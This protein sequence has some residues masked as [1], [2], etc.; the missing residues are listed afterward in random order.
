[1]V[2]PSSTVS[3]VEVHGYEPAGADMGEAHEVGFFH[4]AVRGRHGDEITLLELADRQIGRYIL[5]GGH[6]EDI[7]YG[8]ALGGPA[9]LGYVIDL[10]R[11]DLPLV[12]KEED[13]AVGRGYEEVGDKILLFG[14]HAH[15]PLAAPLLYLEQARRVPLYIA[16]AGDG[17]DHVLLGY[18]VLE[19]YLACLIDYLGAPFVA[20]PLPYFLELVYDDGHEKSF[21]R[22]Y[23]LEARYQLQYVLIL[24]DYLVPL[25]GGKPLE[26][27]VEDGL[28]LYLRELEVC[29]EAALGLLRALRGPDELYDRVQVV[30]GD[31]QPLK[32][33]RPL[34]G[35]LEVE[36]YPSGDD[37]PP[38][39]D[40]LFEERSQGQHPGL[41]LDDGEV[42]YAERGLHLGMEVEVV[43][44]DFSHL[45]PLDL[46][47]DPHA[48]AVGLVPDIGYALNLL[49]P[50]E[51]GYALYELRLV[52]HVG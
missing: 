30:E 16:A 50:H 17:D 3:I 19:G 46:H 20:E 45:V 5:V 25:E 43:E 8:L 34:S 7:D 28:R 1:M 22:E 32:D 27:H 24:L 51:V 48:L 47:D 14:G 13:I 37:L 41:A 23:L 36:Y 29:D 33:V 10:E 4:H 9:G 39:L 15:L 6:I 40:E 44:D 35:L 2:A 26:P 52:H 12:G 42:Y 49:V 31:L 21:A 38:E 11:I 18:E